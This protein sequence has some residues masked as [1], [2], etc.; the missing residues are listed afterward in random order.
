MRSLVVAVLLCGLATIP[1]HAQ[2]HAWGLTPELGWS[3][4]SGA[5]HHTTDDVALRVSQTMSA[6]LRLDRTGRTTGLGLTFLYLQSGI[7]E[8]SGTVTVTSND[9]LKVYSLRP[10]FSMKVTHLGAGTL[11]AHAGPAFSRWSVPGEKRLLVSGVAGLS[12]GVPLSPKWE[13]RIRWEGDL[14]ESVFK[15]S[16]LPAGFETR[17]MFQSRLGLGL[18]LG[19]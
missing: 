11:W 15:G 19:L 7:D 6:G 16:D 2:A 3:W 14:G 9:I 18:R 10:E 1:G 12:L 4:F 17:S 8:N 13:L 5:S